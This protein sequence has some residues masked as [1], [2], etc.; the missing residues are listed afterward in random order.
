MERIGLDTNVLVH[1]LIPSSPQHAATRTFLD[2]ELARDDRVFVVTAS[3]LHELVHVVTDPRR[4]DPALKMAEALAAA[5]SF[6]GR[7]N[8]EVVTADEDALALAFHLMHA[9]RLGRKRL[10]DT[11]FA[12]TLIHHGVGVLVTCNVADYAVFADLATVDPTRQ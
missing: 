12:A 9:H 10:A 7:S 5:R 11:I 8:M 4:F 3:I 2:R 1:A 6:L